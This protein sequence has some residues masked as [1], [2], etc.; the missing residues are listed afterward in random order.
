M[1]SCR[2]QFWKTIVL[3][4]GGLMIEVCAGRGERARYRTAYACEGNN[5]KIACENEKLIK[6]LRANYGRFSISICNDQGILDWSVK[7]AAEKSYFV[8]HERCNLV[9]SCIVNVTSHTFGEPCPG[10]YKY[11]EVQYQCMLEF[12]P[13]SSTILSTT[14]S[15]TTRPPIIIPPTRPK[16]TT[17]TTTT[18]LTTTTTSTTTTTTTKR[19]TT[20][21]TSSTSSFKHSSSSSSSFEYDKTF[22]RFQPETITLYQSPSPPPAVYN[23]AQYCPPAILRRIHWNWTREGQI[24]IEKCPDGSMGYARWQC[25]TSPV[26]WLP[27]FPDLSECQSV[28]VDNLHSRIEGEESIVGIATELAVITKTKPLYGGDIRQVSGIVQ[29]LVAKM[30]ATVKDVTDSQ[31]RYQGSPT[32]Q[33]RF[34]ITQEMLELMSEVSS[35]LLEHYHSDSWR[36]L[37]EPEQRS[38]A[39]ALVQGLEES[40]WLLAESLPTNSQFHKIQNNLLVSVRRVQT[41]SVSEVRFPTLEDVEASEWKRMDES[42]TVPSQA[43]LGSAINGV[44]DVVFLAYNKL[45]NFLTA[46]DRG[47][48]GRPLSVGK[49]SNSSHIINSRVLAASIRRHGLASL[50]QPAKIVFRHIQVENVTNPRCV[51]WEFN[52]RLW[53]GEGCWVSLTNKTHTVCSCNHLTNFALLMEVSATENQVTQ[54]V[55]KLAVWIGCGVA[56]TFILM[57]FLLLMLL[58]NLKGDVFTIRKN[59]LFCLF[60][61]EV[62]ILTG[63]AQTANR[64]ICGVVA[65]FLHYAL[66]EVFTWSLLGIFHLFMVVLD[67]F[68][69]STFR[70]S[71]YCGFG[72]SIPAAIVGISAAIDPGSFGQG[73]NF[74]WLKYRN[75]YIMSFAGPAGTSVLASVVLL[76]FIYHRISRRSDT[77]VDAKNKEG[78]KSSLLRSWSDSSLCVLIMLS[79]TWA[80]CLWYLYDASTITMYIFTVSNS[81]QGVLLFIFYCIR[82]TQVRKTLCE[83]LRSVPWLQSCFPN[84]KPAASPPSQYVYTNGMMNSSLP[85]VSGHESLALPSWRFRSCPTTTETRNFIKLDHQ[86]TPNEDVPADDDSGVKDIEEANNVPTSESDNVSESTDQAVCPPLL[87]TATQSL[88]IKTPSNGVGDWMSVSSRCCGACGSCIKSQ[89]LLFS[90]D[91]KKCLGNYRVNY[92]VEHIYETIDSDSLVSRCSSQSCTSEENDSNPFQSQIC[93]KESFSSNDESRAVSSRGNGESVLDHAVL[94]LSQLTVNATANFSHCKTVP[95]DRSNVFGVFAHARNS[96][97]TNNL[98]SQQQFVDLGCVREQDFRKEDYINDPVALKSDNICCHDVST[99]PLLTEDAVRRQNQETSPDTICEPIPKEN[100]Y[101][102]RI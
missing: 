37:P 59:L 1:V 20:R 26:R 93:I 75:F 11:L 71:W 24:A 15:T 82:E 47:V 46:A 9:P 51:F 17:T 102:F 57:T 44:V 90:P 14:S 81:L 42:V 38:T 95:L 62:I 97:R 76:I 54:E 29:R 41:W 61:A 3:I 36:D 34:Q 89:S 16:T 4:I 55:S 40:S 48:F 33:Q 30:A 85:S 49:H 68:D 58:S 5:L 52:N 99:Y 53:S 87:L 10:T 70:G 73:V 45:E 67:V 98:P 31:Q 19:P 79:L 65:G 27:D 2:R 91:F 69:V 18:P 7:C 12:T 80:S 100:S 23:T 25:G 63:I 60:V 86:F 32:N 78:V 22:T 50:H 101:S 64:I 74:C 21:T 83:T 88:A 35:N 66:L 96:P 6:V 84:L 72:Y 56:M 77:S 28:W 43:L 8:I 39:S 94:H 92:S 13:P